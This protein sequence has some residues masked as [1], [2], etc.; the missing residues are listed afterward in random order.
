MTQYRMPVGADQEGFG[1]EY[2]PH[3]NTFTLRTPEGRL[4]TMDI[5]QSDVHIDAALT[6]YASGY[7]N[8]DLCADVVM[9]PVLVNKAS[10]YYFQFDPDDALATVDGTQ[11]AAGANVSEV[12][13]KLSNTRYAT[14]GYALGGFV[15][16]EL[17]Q[18]QDAPLNLEM[19]TTRVVMDRLM[20]NREVRVKT[21]MFNSSNY[22][23]SHLLDLSAL[24]TRKWNGGSAS[25]PVRDI[26]SIVEAS[27]MP[28]TD[29]VMDRKTWNAFITNAAVQKYTAFK[30]NLPALPNLSQ[31]QMFAALLDLPVPHICEARAKDSTGAY[32]YVWAG[33]VVLFRRPPVDVPVDGMDVASAKT[34]RWTG[35]QDTTL[36]APSLQEMKAS[37]GITVRTFHNPY[38]GKKGGTQIIVTH[39][40]AEQ[41]ITDN[42]SGLIK[43]A[44]V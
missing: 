30:V 40:D 20:L 44:F 31:R 23:G 10:D 2:D 11:V 27:L 9:P 22:T 34:F 33:S 1:G 36:G 38:R 19:K 6:N 32:P 29:M 28:I 41:F 21:V 42:V 12:T 3:N 43:A 25:D 17:I 5:G 26:Q 8:A 24:P 16:V 18:N 37:G 15:P 4:V 39:D 13:P 14:L 35:G 7:H